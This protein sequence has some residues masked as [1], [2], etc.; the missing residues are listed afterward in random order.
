MGRHLANDAVRVRRQLFVEVHRAEMVR[1]AHGRTACFLSRKPFEFAELGNL[2]LSAADAR[3]ECPR[4]G[5][6]KL[7]FMTA[8]A[9]K[10]ELHARLSNSCLRLP[11]FGQNLKSAAS[12]ALLPP[13]MDFATFPIATD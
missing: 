11:V 1:D 8:C 9:A 2:H 4:A 6:S 13:P 3:N 7:Q 12:Q 10:M 5:R